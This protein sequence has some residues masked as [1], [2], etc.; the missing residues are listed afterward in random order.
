MPLRTRQRHVAEAVG[1]ERAALL[2][3]PLLGGGLLLL[4]G[5]LALAF[6]SVVGSLRRLALL[7]VFAPACRLRLRPT[8][9]A[10]L[11]ASA[12]A[13]HRRHRDETG[14]DEQQHLTRQADDATD[15]GGEGCAFW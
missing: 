12:V 9:R 2:L 11:D 13:A 14:D 7:L 15:G 1:D 3:P 8:L 5:L 4:H 10:L 6:A